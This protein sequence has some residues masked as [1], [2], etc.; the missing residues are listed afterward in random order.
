MGERVLKSVGNDLQNSKKTL[1]E[2]EKLCKSLQKE[3]NAKTLSDRI[4]VLEKQKAE[5]DKKSFDLENEKSTLG[6]RVVSR[7]V[8][9]GHLFSPGRII[10]RVVCVWRLDC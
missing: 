5:L 2:K 9:R 8:D 3:D 7:P 4:S 10:E 6:E 1:E